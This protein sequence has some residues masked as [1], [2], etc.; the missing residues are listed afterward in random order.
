MVVLVVSSPLEAVGEPKFWG[1]PDPSVVKVSVVGS[2]S[3]VVETS[4]IISELSVVVIYVASSAYWMFVVL[5]YVPEVSASLVEDIFEL[6]L[7]ISMVIYK[8][9]IYIY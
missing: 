9:L 6:I 1:G 2:A 3:V 7:L 5:K 8:L 4:V